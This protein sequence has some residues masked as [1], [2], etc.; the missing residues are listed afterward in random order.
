M[1]WPGGIF[2]R[3]SRYAD[4]SAS[5]REHLAEKVDELVERGMPRREA[6]SIARREFGNATLIEQ[7]GREVWQWRFVEDLSAD[8]RFALRQYATSP[9]FAL[10]ALLTLA[11]GIGAQTAMYSVV[12]AVL[13]NPFPYRGAMRMVHLHLY[14]K[15]PFPEDLSLNGPQFTEFAKSPV[16]DG[17]VAE[18][19]YTM[20]LTREKLPEQL[21]IG[22]LS[23][24]AFE[25]F[26][27]P[28][29]LGR[30][31]SPSD[32]PRVA[33][34]SYAFWKSH[35]AGSA[36]AIGSA[37]QLDHESYTILGVMPPRFAWLGSDAYIPLAWSADPTHVANVYAR[38]RP[39]VSDAAAGQALAPMLYAFAKQTPGNFPPRFKVHIVPINEIAI[40]RFKNVLVVLFA[41]VSFLLLLA[42]VNVAIL[43]LARGEARQAEMAM[44]KAL[45][46]GRRRILQQLLTESLLL[47]A[48]GGGLGILLAFGAIRLV[49]HFLI[50]LP[51]LFPPEASIEL[52]LP[53]LAFS[54]GVSILTG[55]VCGIWPALRTSRAGLRRAAD[56]G[57]PRLG[58]PRGMRNVHAMLLAVQAAV[59]VLLLSCSGAMVVRLSHLVRTA[60][61]YELTNLASVNFVLRE[62]S[63]NDWAGRV[64]F[65]ER[66]RAA[67]ASDPA[68]ESAAIG[69][70][71][72]FIIDS[73]PIAIP[74]LPG[75]A[76]HVVEEQVSP[77][78]FATLGIPLLRGRLWTPSETAHAM[79]L[80]VINDAARR[81]YWPGADPVGQTLVLN[82]G[83][84]RGT[85]WRV[86]APG[87]DQHFQ[88]IGVVGDSPNQGIEEQTS[89]AVYVPFTMMPFDGFD[90]A[91]RTRPGA[92]SLLQSIREDVYRVDAG[93][94]V[95]AIRTA[96]DLLDGSL[97]RE[98]F[99]AGVST[100]FAFLG[101][102][103]ALSGLYSVQSYL[104]AQRTREIGVRMALGAKRSN[105][106]RLV[107][108][109][110][111]L[112]VS[113]GALFGLAINFAL[114]R[115]FAAWTA[116]DSR[117]PAMIGA[118]LMILLAGAA[119]A[120]MAPAA[121]A[122]K[123]APVDAL[124]SE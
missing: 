39:G 70:L 88:I 74:A 8:F 113:S 76:G 101:L 10:A 106:V 23:P 92:G 85:E 4:L 103:F 9:R 29:A 6:E 107:T 32:N 2:S 16:L 63:H 93:Q 19:V 40:G 72:P 59:T 30:G 99:M 58:G 86:V 52:N 49:R 45:G 78:Y 118:I 77:E 44:R 91:M 48:S 35:Y 102:V 120:S 14:D 73:T 67:I 79:R 1:S 46:A 55:V 57:A 119:L 65:F 33:V 31:I 123:I 12:H 26:G 89:P 62:N 60:L 121:A 18:D 11:V 68:V 42:C 50:A 22:R 84:A 95:G 24:N 97:G 114:S 115:R 80:A 47:S 87:D 116:A 15:D 109:R 27:V 61:G 3:R 51:T 53:V 100:L 21:Q 5:I 83:I 94:A 71:P 37:L 110:A 17:A 20:A 75:A 64:A 112:A 104:V 124:R 90:V 82:N 7:R 105:I 122:M 56:A 13:V 66:I 111:I 54:L 41:S 108:T 38:L 98:R 96:T 81:R 28:A 25:Y 117:D 69:N 43:L 36:D 34:L